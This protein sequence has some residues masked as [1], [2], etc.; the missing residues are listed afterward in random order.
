MTAG[1][2]LDVSGQGVL[3][4]GL[5]ESSAGGRISLSSSSGN[6]T[7]DAGSTLDLSAGTG[8]GAGGALSMAAPEGAV[9]LAGS[10][11]GA[12]GAGS[13][14]ASLSV[15]AQ[16][17]NFPAL[18][19]LA[20][21]SGMTGTF[22][23]HERGPGDLILGA[24]Q[25]LQSSQITLTADAG[26]IDVA[27]VLTADSSNGGLIDLNAQ[28]NIVV[29]GQLLATAT[30][31]AA[32]GGTIDLFS[33]SGGVYVNADALLNVGGQSSSGAAL[34]ST[35]QVLITMPRSAAL[36]LLAGAPQVSLAGSIEGAAQIQLEGNQVYSVPAG[37]LPALDEL[38]D[39]SNP[40]YADA[41]TFMQNA[42]AIE[43]AIL[44]STGK[45]VSVLPGIQI[46][47]PGDLTIGSSFDLSTWR[48]GS[49][50]GI[51]TLQAAGNVNV[52]SSIT[53]GF[54]TGSYTLSS[55]PSASWSYR[56][57]AG[58]DLS[59]AN[60]LGLADPSTLPVTGASV[61]LA[62][63][64]PASS[65]GV[66]NAPTMIRTGTGFIDI[67]AA[68]D[69]VLGNQASVIYTA[70]EAG[71][72]GTP[73][74]ALQNLPYPVNGGSITV[75][76]ARDVVGATSG[77]LFTDWLWRTAQSSGK[78]GVVPTAWTVNFGTFEQ[79]IGA[80]A[81]GDLAV[82]AGG[83]ILDLGA[84]VPTVGAPVSGQT[85][86]IEENVGGLL[87]V[88]AGGNILGGKFLNMA[89][90]A[91]LSAGGQ[92][93]EGSLQAGASRG[94]YPPL[95]MG[96]SRFSVTA[97]SGITIEAVLD[98]TLVESSSQQSA[99]TFQPY[100]TYNG[101]S[102]VTLLSAGGNVSLINDGLGDLRR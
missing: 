70:G 16:S 64:V 38:A 3:F 23:V 49:T 24:S 36:S 12:G 46:Q 67:A 30:G 101:H 25:T 61:I 79:G 88:S 51:L 91:T 6:V 5:T 4:D 20:T 39:P 55:T 54:A 83:H 33:A 58:A 95:A 14:G 21:S 81:G 48:F 34:A 65:R 57:T 100:A 31:N 37:S 60:P 63:G 75:T 86:P 26:S 73:V 9:T 80:L 43:Q 47:S 15:D 45:T 89:G 82:T 17:L 77:D 52:D 74:S 22:S 56:I 85:A 93:G 94:L 40:L 78:G 72:V 8:Q 69:L 99:Q 11:L 18:V 27:G 96:D 29:D 7:V 32:R 92:I 90:S 62:P 102:S 50:P 53:D 59:G 84:V 66:P 1:A 98:P 44:A 28:Q 10:V 68:Q 42:G 71:S 2:S 41:T 19:A 87:T 35:G 97:A 76:V 13:P